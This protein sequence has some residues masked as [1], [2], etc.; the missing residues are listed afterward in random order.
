MQKQLAH[1]NQNNTGCSLFQSKHNDT[2]LFS[3]EQSIDLLKQKIGEIQKYIRETVAELEQG[4]L[5]T[6]KCNYSSLGQLTLTH[7]QTRSW[8]RKFKNLKEQWY[9]K[10]L[11][12]LLFNRTERILACIDL[13]LVFGLI[14]FPILIATILSKNMP[15]SKYFWLALFASP[16]IGIALTIFI[17]HNHERGFL[18]S[19]YKPKTRPLKFLQNRTT[20]AQKAPTMFDELFDFYIHELKLLKHAAKNT[21]NPFLQQAAH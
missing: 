16:C 18:G 8:I 7:E 14:Y 15:T 10:T 12:T 19:F 13:I 20:I 9:D 5:I 3:N 1:Y 6:S 21:L 2:L 11:P 4:N 17:A